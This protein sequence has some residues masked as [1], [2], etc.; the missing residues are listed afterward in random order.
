MMRRSLPEDARDLGAL[1]RG[2]R[3]GGQ[4]RLPDV[5]DPDELHDVLLSL[6]ALPERDGLRS[7]GRPTSR[8]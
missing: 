5:R 4:R 2:D 7:S 8:R 6:G 1:D 3:R